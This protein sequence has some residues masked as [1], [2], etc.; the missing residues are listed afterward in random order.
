MNKDEKESAMSSASQMKASDVMGNQV[1]QIEVRQLA[2]VELSTGDRASA[3]RYHSVLAM[4]A[5][6]KMRRTRQKLKTGQMVCHH[7]RMMLASE[8]STSSSERQAQ[9]EPQ[10]HLGF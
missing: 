1:D 7:L 10:Y 2:A 9:N 5:A 6:R 4:E 3:A 8:P